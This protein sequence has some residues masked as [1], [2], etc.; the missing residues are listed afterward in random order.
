MSANV[1]QITSVEMIKVLRCEWNV[2]QVWR[3]DHTDVEMGFMM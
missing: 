3:C 2:I 1:I